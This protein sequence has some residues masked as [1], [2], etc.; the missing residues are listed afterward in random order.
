MGTGKEFAVRQMIFGICNIII[1]ICVYYT[2]HFVAKYDR[3][4]AVRFMY[5]ALVISLLF[6]FI[7][8][9]IQVLINY[10]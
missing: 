2:S 1:V 3:K 4:L 10:L 5:I 8:I 7:Q 9:Q 6:E